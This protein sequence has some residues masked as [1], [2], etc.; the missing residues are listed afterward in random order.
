MATILIDDVI[1][2]TYKKL[3]FV[4]SNTL[5]TSNDGVTD[6]EPQLDG[7]KLGSATPLTATSVELNYLDGSTPGTSVANKALVV[8]GSSAITGIGTVGCG[9]ITS[10]GIIKTD[11]STEAASTTD[12]SLQT[13][14]GLSVVKDCVF[15]NDVKFL[16]DSALLSFGVDGD[17]TLLHTDGLGLTLN[18]TNKICFN[19]SSQFIQGSSDAILSLGATDEIDLTATAIDINGTVD[20]SGNAVLNGNVTLGTDIDSVITINGAL[21]GR[22]ALIFEGN[23]SNAHE[24]TFFITE[25]TGDHV[26]T[27]PAATG[28]V[29][30]SDNTLALT[31]K[32]LGATTMSGALETAGNSIT[33]TT[34]ASSTLS[35]WTGAGQINIGDNTTATVAM[36]NINLK[37]SSGSNT[38]SE[39]QIAD[40]GVIT[41]KEASGTEPFK[42]DSTSNK[43]I[44][45]GTDATWKSVFNSD[46][47]VISGADITL[48]DQ[49]GLKFS[50]GSEVMT[51]QRPANLADNRT[52]TLPDKNGE[53]LVQASAAGA[54]TEFKGF[55]GKSRIFKYTDTNTGGGASA[56]TLSY[57]GWTIVTGSTST[58]TDLTVTAASAGVQR[59]GLF[60]ATSQGTD[61]AYCLFYAHQDAST[62]TVQSIS[63]A[64]T[65]VAMRG[66]AIIRLTHGSNDE[67][68]V[69]QIL[70]D[71]YLQSIV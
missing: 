39:I 67:I 28:T 5:F 36:K 51:I 22:N 3:A 61:N 46:I 27:F 9:A 58:T 32:T 16:S 48:K 11:D 25:P 47:E 31:N 59:S 4:D 56:E 26:I 55:S 17:T 2:E 37:S 49:D 8:G 34:A 66:G 30:L 1:N 35:L 57:F 52:I 21:A 64:G 65:T 44:T 19:D 63:N 60:L 20:I 50:D 23:T 41:V 12:G 68:H 13:D 18:S 62:T 45:L 33:R 40:D 54:T 71:I 24:T 15:G 14:G 42:I 38:T 7:L 29:A 70:G 10:S 43:Q 53:L 6:T 69:W